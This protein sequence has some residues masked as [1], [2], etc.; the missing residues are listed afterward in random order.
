MNADDSGYANFIDV[1]NNSDLAYAFKKKRLRYLR[2]ASV[3]KEVLWLR[4]TFNSIWEQRGDLYY[5]KDPALSDK[6]REIIQGLFGDSE[7]AMA[8]L[9]IDMVLVSLDRIRI[10][11]FLQLHIASK[12]AQKNLSSILFDGEDS[13]I[14]LV[15][16]QIPYLE[17]YIPTMEKF[18]GR[19]VSDIALSQRD[20]DNILHFLSQFDSIEKNLS[21]D[22]LRYKEFERDFLRLYRDDVK[23][24]VVGYGEISTVMRLNKNK[25]IRVDI[26]S[27]ESMWIWKKMPPFPTKDEVDRFLKLYE[28]YRRILTEDIDIMVPEQTARFFRH[29]T[30]YQVYAGQ[31][32]VGAE[33]ICNVLIKKLDEPNANRLLSMILKRICAVYDFNTINSAMKIGIDAQLSNWALDSKHGS[34]SAVT[35]NERII[36]IDT[37]TPMIRIQ[38]IEKINPEIFIKSAAS[39]LRPIIRRFF[40]QQVLDRYYDVR[41]VAIDIIA[42]L[43]K[44]KREDLINS[45]IS[46]TNDCFHRSGIGVEDI[47]RKEIDAYYSD[48]A[49]IWKFYL[50]SRKIDRFI[51]EK[52]LRK[53]YMYRIPE[54]IER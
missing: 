12:N 3:S 43:Y 48:D 25:Q 27:T 13:L 19:H 20:L 4:D 11:E 30:F 6:G 34:P 52:I 32:C 46:T 17:Q 26:V 36:Y 9:K 23:V 14:S 15:S 40:L 16:R 5:L 2:S 39:F 28:E 49:F 7:K 53:K 38:G 31:K 22:I 54:N 41:S 51:T 42:N 45:F 24:D 8:I 21:R 44:E 29:D 33:T 10:N 47:T 50:S 37:S 1:V 18:N 35:G